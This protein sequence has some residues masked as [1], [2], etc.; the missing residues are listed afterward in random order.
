MDSESW[1]IL[2]VRKHSGKI[3][4][5]FKFCLQRLSTYLKKSERDGVTVDRTVL[6]SIIYMNL[7]VN[8]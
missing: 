3:R 4:V 8:Q 2:S 1:P 7:N 6:M 5:S